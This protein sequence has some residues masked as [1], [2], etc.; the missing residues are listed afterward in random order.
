M[1]SENKLHPKSWIPKPTFGVH[2]Y[3][4]IH[5]RFQITDLIKYYPAGHSKP[6][7]ATVFPY[8]PQHPNGSN[9]Q[10]SR[11]LTEKTAKQQTY[12]LRPSLFSRLSQIPIRCQCLFTKRLTFCKIRASLP[13]H[14]DLNPINHRAAWIKP[15]SQYPYYCTIIFI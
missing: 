10:F 9:G 12:T 14:T 2:F 11:C 7:P 5:R 13:F 6:Q 8:I 4:K 15:F 1:P 3:D